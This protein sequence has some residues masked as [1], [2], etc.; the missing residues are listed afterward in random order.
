M[1]MK[2]IVWSI[3]II[4][5]ISIGLLIVYIRLSRLKKPP[6]LMVRCS[7]GT[8]KWEKEATLGVY[9]WSWFGGAVQTE[10]MS[11]LEMEERGLITTFLIDSRDAYITLYF[12]QSEVRFSVDS[13][14]ITGDELETIT[15]SSNVSKNKKSYSFIA[16][17][18]YVYT[19]N[20]EYKNGTVTYAFAVKPDNY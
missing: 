4:L 8:K 2:V 18:N 15:S 9:R 14:S 5:L 11:P 13:E 7:A 20:V 10:S 12:P 6:N 3:I 17:I 16:K 19:V 1:K